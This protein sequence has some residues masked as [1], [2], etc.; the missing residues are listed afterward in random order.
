M[1][2]ETS[3]LETLIFIIVINF[4][5]YIVLLC[6]KKRSILGELNTRALDPIYVFF[7]GFT[8]NLCVH[9]FRPMDMALDCCS[10]SLSHLVTLVVI[11]GIGR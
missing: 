9:F 11:C 2:F 5:W 8:L 6:K 3:I 7:G 10:H 4:S 1:A